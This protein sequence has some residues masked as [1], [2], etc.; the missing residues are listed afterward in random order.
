V[1]S[2]PNHIY[3]LPALGSLAV[4]VSLHALASNS[5]DFAQSESAQG[6]CKPAI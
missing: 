2:I 3:D 5:G 6:G 4:E 1:G